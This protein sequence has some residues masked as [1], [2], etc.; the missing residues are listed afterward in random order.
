MNTDEA[1][2]FVLQYLLQM[3]QEYPERQV[4]YSRT[5]ILGATDDSARASVGMAVDYLEDEGFLR[6]QSQKNIKFYRLSSRAQDHLLAPSAY[7]QSN[8]R[9][10]NSVRIINNDGGIVMMGDNYGTVTQDR[11]VQITNQLNELTNIIRAA[12]EVSDEQKADL[13]QNAVTL[14]AQVRKPTPDTTIIQRAWTA[15]QGAAT[16]SG[17][18]Q[19]IEQLRPTVEHVIRTAAGG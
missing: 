17:A 19:L 14:Q 8:R 15:M 7:S 2:D 3:Q 12:A 9:P 6:S 13:I 11:R 16:I 1:K 5:M 18:V 10:E 4:G